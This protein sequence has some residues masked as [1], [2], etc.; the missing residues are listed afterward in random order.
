MIRSALDGRVVLAH[1]SPSGWNSAFLLV[2][3]V[4]DVWRTLVLAMPTCE[5][6]EEEAPYDERSI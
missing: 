2:I 6:C 5:T 4:E 3:V 1:V